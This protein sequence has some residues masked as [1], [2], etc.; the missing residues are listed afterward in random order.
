MIIE[1]FNNILSSNSLMPTFLVFLV[2]FYM[3]DFI[4]ITHTIISCIITIKNA[5]KIVLKLRIE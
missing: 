3:S 1:L 2:Y 4:S 5:M